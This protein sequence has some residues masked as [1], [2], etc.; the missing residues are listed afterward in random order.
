MHFY[1]YLFNSKEVS[2]MTGINLMQR[3]VSTGV[4][5]DITGGGGEE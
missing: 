4:S 1:F 2:N 3:F 5:P